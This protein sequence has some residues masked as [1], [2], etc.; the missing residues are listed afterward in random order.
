MRRAFQTVWP[1]CCAYYAHNPFTGTGDEATVESITR[2]DLL[3]WHRMWFTPNGR[4]LIV[5]GDVTMAQLEPALAR[6]FGSWARGEAP[7][8]SIGTVA[9]SVGTRSGTPART[10]HV[11]KETSRFILS[12][13]RLHSA[14]RPIPALGF[15]NTHRWVYDLVSDVG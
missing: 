10:N 7:N 3:R 6:A 5:T 4:T 1:S 15:D 8:K 13:G 2:D 14:V 12:T 9:R 11:T